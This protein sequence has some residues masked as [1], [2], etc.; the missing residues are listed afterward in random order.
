MCCILAVSLVVVYFVW[1]R[2]SETPR[3]GYCICHW[4]LVDLPSPGVV[5]FSALRVRNDSNESI[6][7]IPRQEGVALYPYWPSRG[8][9]L[10]SCPSLHSHQVARPFVAFLKARRNY[11]SFKPHAGAFRPGKDSFTC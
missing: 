2:I 8:S 9:Q 4:K 1:I 6:L 7:K 3:I 5:S 10:A 11:L